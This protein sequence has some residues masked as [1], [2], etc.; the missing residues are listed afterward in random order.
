MG[1]DGVRSAGTGTQAGAAP[2]FQAKDLLQNG[3]FTLTPEMKADL[4]Q[5][6]DIYGKEMGEKYT[7]PAGAKAEQQITEWIKAHPNASEEA[8]IDAVK[9]FVNDAVVEQQ[10]RKIGDDNFMN[11]ICSKIG[12]SMKF[13]TDTWEE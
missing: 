10:T 6:K 1:V 4:A 13:D 8:T 3:K 2:T 11:Q 7:G 12:A 5:A 9:K